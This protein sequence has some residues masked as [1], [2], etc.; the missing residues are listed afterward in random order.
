MRCGN[1]D[2][3]DLDDDQLK[4][5]ASDSYF[6][7]EVFVYFYEQYKKTT[8]SADILSPFEWVVANKLEVSIL[9][10]YHIDITK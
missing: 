10:V 5:A 3:I 4:Y 7:R 6:S 8:D 1:W 9:R 2:S